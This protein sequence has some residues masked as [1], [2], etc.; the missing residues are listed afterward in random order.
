MSSCYFFAFYEP[1]QHAKPHKSCCAIRSCPNLR[2]GSI[3]VSF[4]KQHSGGHG[5]TKIL[6]VAVRENVWE[7]LKLGLI[8]GYSCPRFL[9]FRSSVIFLVPRIFSPQGLHGFQNGASFCP[10]TPRHPSG[11]EVLD[12]YLGKGEPL[13]VWNLTQF[14]TKTPLIYMPC[15][16]QHP[17]ILLHC[18]GQRTKCTRSCF[19]AIYWQLQ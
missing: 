17:S 5:E 14:R 2:S 13:R 18:L 9:T 11:G 8:S 19:K 3:F 10:P 1:A 15:F 4:C 12:Q 7:P 16:G 6:A